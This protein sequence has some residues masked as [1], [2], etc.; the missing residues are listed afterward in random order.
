TNIAIGGHIYVTEKAGPRAKAYDF[1]GKLLAV[2]AS[3]VFDANCK[4]M[5][6]AACPG[7]RVAVTD[8]VRNSILMFAP[9][10]A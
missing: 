10:T 9:V 8:T 1:S 6:I 7:G 5:Y 2:I 4:N 3:D